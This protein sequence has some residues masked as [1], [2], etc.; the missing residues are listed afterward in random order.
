MAALLLGHLPPASDVCLGSMA[1]RALTHAAPAVDL[2]S[3]CSVGSWHAALH[4]RLL[5]SACCRKWETV[6][7]CNG[8]L[9]GLVG[10]TAGCSVVEP[11]AAMLCGAIAAIVFGVADHATLYVAKIDDPVSAFSLHAVAG[12]FGV[13]FP[14]F[15]ARPEYVLQVCSSTLHHDGR[16][17]GSAHSCMPSSLLVTL[18]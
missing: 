13:L 5:L 2:Y 11:W 3:L 1:W 8:V 16:G 15:M 7:V 17:A 12:A 10:I 18:L 6:N 14:G 9:A 4:A